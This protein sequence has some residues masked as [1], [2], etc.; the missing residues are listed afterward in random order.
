M[1]PTHFCTCTRGPTW[2]RMPCQPTP[3]S[4]ASD[5]RDLRIWAIPFSTFKFARLTLKLRTWDIETDSRHPAARGQD[6]Q[7]QIASALSSWVCQPQRSTDAKSAKHSMHS[8]SGA[9]GIRLLR[10][11]AG[12]MRDPRVLV[13]CLFL[14][15]T[16]RSMWLEAPKY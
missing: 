16:H 11:S 13:L 9:R 6:D 2:I 12:A 15:S 1:Q 7:Q 4:S 3:S 10:T 5:T 8:G 14:P